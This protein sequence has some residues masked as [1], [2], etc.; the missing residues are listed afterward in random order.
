MINLRDKI[1]LISEFSYVNFGIFEIWKKILTEIL[2]NKKKI[3]GDYDTH[4]W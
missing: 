1:S 3:L 2:E 4:V